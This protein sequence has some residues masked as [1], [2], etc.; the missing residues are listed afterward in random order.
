[1]I[2]LIRHG[3]TARRAAAA[4]ALATSLLTPA[5]RADTPDASAPG[6]TGHDEASADPKPIAYAQ[7]LHGRLERGEIAALDG[8]AEL[9]GAASGDRTGPV[10]ASMIRCFGP[11]PSGTTPSSPIPSD[12]IASSTLMLMATYRPLDGV[13]EP[14]AAYFGTGTVIMAETGLNRVLTAAHVTAPELVVPTG[15]PVRLD[16]VH[17]FDGEG[18]LVAR[19]GLT[20][21]HTGRM[22]LGAIT[23]ELLHD[24]FAVL[25]PVAFPTE[26]MARSWQGRGVEVAP[27]QSRSVLF[28]YGDGG[29]SFVA[30]GFSG[31][32]L[33]NPEGQAVGLISETLSLPQTSRPAPNTAMPEATLSA[34]LSLMDGPARRILTDIASGASEGAYVDAVAAGPPLSSPRLLAALG[35]DPDRIRTVPALE[36]TRLFSAGYPGREC[37]SSWLILEPR[38]DVPLRETASRHRAVALADPVIYTDRPGELL[39]LSPAGDVLTPVREKGFGMIDFLSTVDALTRTGG[40][41]PVVSDPFAGGEPEL[42]GPR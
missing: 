4:L 25:A 2:D 26:E 35:V 28:F 41:P 33:L 6:L 16:T 36:T 30:P 19:L 10:D 37:R 20:F 21:A 18:R 15:E 32:A 14:I 27:E 38:A 29:S 39:T 24:D 34:D 42:R 23:H 31:A 5:A 40:A 17:A 1:M 13:G 11:D 7:I 22:Q 12:R 3:V 8:V 9:S